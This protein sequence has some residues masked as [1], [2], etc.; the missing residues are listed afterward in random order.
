MEWVGWQEVDNTEWEAILTWDR[1][2]N[3][4]FTVFAG[5]NLIGISNDLEDT[6][7]VL[8]IQYLL[9]LNLESRAWIDSDGGARFNLGKFFELTPRLA[10]FGKSQYDTHDLW[11]GS[12]G[13][14]YLVHK[15]FTLVGQWHSDYGFGGGLQIRF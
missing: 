9:P 5:A 15:N 13:L 3:R 10:L 11:E 6:R 1:Y 4:F 8:G 7:A 12:A 2:I 14:S